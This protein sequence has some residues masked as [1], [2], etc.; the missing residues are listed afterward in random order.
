MKIY[1][2]GKIVPIE[3]AGIP[4][5]DRGFLYGDGVF[6]SLR[7]YGRRPFLLDQHLKRLS[8]AA[9]LLNIRPP[10]L[11]AGLKRAIMRT[12]VANRFPELYLKVILT[13]GENKGHG[14]DPSNSTGK[15]NLVI[16]A[17]SLKEYPVKGWKA[18]ISS[19]RRTEVPTSHIK[20]LCYLDN[21]IA[22]AEARK[23]GADE[24]LML[25]EKGRVVE[26]T[27]SNIFMVKLGAIYTPPVDEPILAG[28]TR[29]LAIRLA[30]HANLRVVEKM[31]DPKAL[32]NCDECF[33]TSSGAG[34]I[35]VTKIGRKKIGGD[36]CGPLTRRMIELYKAETL[37]EL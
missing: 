12:I 6:E 11:L 4:I 21:I 35:P 34:I 20:S 36:K 3:K 9:R 30:K 16:I 27:V 25:D 1:I 18:I 7:T 24:A 26:G 32:Y 10:L 14:L 23:A 13:R 5:L 8:S 29:G 19:I 33:V 15:P 37:K 2:N 22:K 31:I 17:E 28:I